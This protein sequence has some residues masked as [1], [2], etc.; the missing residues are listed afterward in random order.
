M[1]IVLAG[2]LL[3]GLQI[4]VLTAWAEPD[5]DSRGN[6]SYSPVVVV[7]DVSDSMSETGHSGQTK[8]AAARAAVLDLVNQTAPETPFALV[9]YPGSNARSVDGCREGREEV[10]LGKL[11]HVAAAAAVRRLTP[12][13]DTPTGPALEH[14]ARI[15]NQ[16]GYDEG[17]I[18]LVSDGE[19]NCGA[20]PCQVAKQLDAH[21]VEVTISTVSLQISEAGADELRCI[22]DATGGRYAEVDDPDKLR[23]TLGAIAGPRLDINADVAAKLPAVSGT[24]TSGTTIPIKVSNTGRSN[25]EDVRVSLDFRDDANL[26]GAI[27]VPRPVR[28]LGNLA[29]GQQRT[30][31]VIVRPDAAR[32]G[33]FTWIAAA[34]AHNTVPDIDDGATSVVEPFG[35]LTGLLADVEHAAILGDS[36]SSGEGT[37]SYADRTDDNTNGNLCHRSQSA[38]GPTLF[39]DRARIIACSAAVT[40]DFYGEQTSGAEKMTPQLLAL[41]AQAVGPDSPDAVL[42]SIGGN[43]IGFVPTVLMCL[44]NR[45]LDPR[46]QPAVWANID[47]LAVNL[48]R[49]YRDIDR[50]VNDREALSR[51]GGTAPIVVVPYPRVTPVNADDAGG[52]FALISEP[53]VTFLNQLVDRLN[54]QIA[55]VTRS[56]RNEGLPVY[57]AA[58]V[59]SAF[60]PNHTI[61]DGDQSYAG[62][63]GRRTSAPENI[64]AADSWTELAHPNTKGYAAMARA[65]SA[66]SAKLP[67]APHHQ[68]D[69]WNDDTVRPMT[70]IARWWAH[71]QMSA[72]Q[73]YEAGGD[74]QVT[75]DGFAP[76]STVIFRINSTPRVLGGST[77]DSN[78]TVDYTAWIPNDLPPG[79]HTIRV[80][81]FTATG[82]PHEVAIPVRVFAPHSKVSIALLVVGIL[83]TLVGIAGFRTNPRTHIPRGPDGK[84]LRL[85]LRRNH[86]NASA[87]PPAQPQSDASAPPS[88]P[89]HTKQQPPPTEGR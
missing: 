70:P 11:D 8:I 69:D 5:I 12:D 48:A 82:Q 29:P 88:T 68:A 87:T 22:A 54:S 37:R 71:Q 23:D 57:Y 42:L 20:D 4:P 86:Q 31:E 61:C 81:G 47:A 44:V 56:L 28:F 1:R 85:R 3:V 83:V 52:C 72:V 40:G 89:N 60:Q 16:A 26:P 51:R 30:V 7:L 18:V 17:T 76:T 80:I 6:T 25:A 2:I 75:A 74:V 59:F 9:A 19:S 32:L 77:T 46:V 13:G 64:L 62:T 45:C 36:Y 78:G 58:D 66:F 43:D 50:A 73:M 10:P 27:L 15:M 53:E 21:G 49:V 41:R 79:S 34:T 84:R 38:Y 67:P 35:T 24:G 63:A 14:A 39:G 65:I 33:S 55:T